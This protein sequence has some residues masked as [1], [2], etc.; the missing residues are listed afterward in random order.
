MTYKQKNINIITIYKPEKGV[1]LVKKEKRV[2]IKKNLDKGV[3]VMKSLSEI[4]QSPER[5]ETERI[6]MDFVNLI[7]VYNLI[8]LKILFKLKKVV[9]NIGENGYDFIAQVLSA[10]YMIPETKIEKILDQVKN[11][12]NFLKEEDLVLT[13]VESSDL[14]DIFDNKNRMNFER[15]MRFAVDDKDR[16]EKELKAKD[17]VIARLMNLYAELINGEEKKD[18]K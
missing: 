11:L 14:I 9:E 4:I 15:H 17:K 3:D 6:I 5:V 16:T 7:P 18:G 1:E 10:V 12:P 8:A 13:V 2:R